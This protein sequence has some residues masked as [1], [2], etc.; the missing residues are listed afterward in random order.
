MIRKLLTART[1][2]ELPSLADR[3]KDFRDRYP[4]NKAVTRPATA[5]RML[6]GRLPESTQTPDSDATERKEQI[7]KKLVGQL[8]GRLA[9][10]VAVLTGS[11]AEKSDVPMN[12]DQA[13]ASQPVDQLETN[14]KLPNATHPTE[15]PITPPADFDHRV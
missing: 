1:T 3:A 4:S 6:Y 9:A 15:S 2:P 13:P 14:W 11:V 7:A 5:D 10:S 8:G 12:G